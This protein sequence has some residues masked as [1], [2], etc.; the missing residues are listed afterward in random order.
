MTRGSSCGSPATRSR[1]TGVRSPPRRGRAPPREHDGPAPAPPL[2]QRWN[3]TDREFA[4]GATLPVLLDAAA[5]AH[6][7]APAVRTTSGVA[8]THGELAAASRRMARALVASGVRPGTP[9]ALLVD[10]LPEAVAAVH[11][12]VRAGAF[13]V[14]LD[15][16]WPVRRTADVMES[17]GARHLVVTAGHR[18]AAAHLQDALAQ[19]PSVV[20]AELLP[21]PDTWRP[22]HVPEPD[23]LAYTIFTSGSTGL[24]K[25]VAIQHTGVVNL[26]D[27]FNRRNGVGPDDV[28]LQTAAFSF[29][30]SV[31]DLFGTLAAGASILLL[32]A[33]EL[34]DPEQIADALVDHGVTLWNSAPALFT[35]VSFF[36]TDD[37]R[38]RR[39]HCAGSSSAVTGSRSARPHSSG[40]SFPG[41]P[42]WRWAAPPR[43][44]SGPTTSRSGRW[45]RAGRASPTA[46]RCR[47]RATT[48]CA[49]I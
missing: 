20:V 45:T 2:I 36:L 30:L 6:P 19:A 42:W 46:R 25:A 49:R 4:T 8:L 33:A 48:S 17:I 37:S 26:I 34:G 28:L 43:H 39:G 24:P 18:A 7:D 32:P 12:I 23:D 31:Y 27:W 10:H 41:R 38:D 44:V 29:D 1:R 3:A 13:Y 9:V 15:P 21:G 14:P 11:A 22:A 40:R 16:R 35:T 5:T 47:T